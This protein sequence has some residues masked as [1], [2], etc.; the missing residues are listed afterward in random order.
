MRGILVVFLSLFFCMALPLEAKQLN[1]LPRYLTEDLAPADIAKVVTKGITNEKK[2]AEA[3]ARF[4]AS[5]Y[6]RDGFLEKERLNAFKKKKV[7]VPEYENNFFYSK[8]GDSYGFSSLY[9]ELCEAVGLTAVIIE[10]YAGKNIYAYANVRPEGQVVRVASSMLTGKKDISL[11]R[12]K[13]AWNGVKIKDK[14]ILVDTYWMIRGEKTAHKNISSA[15][16]M[17]R[18]LKKAEKQPLKKVNNAIDMTFFD[19][20]PR[21]F[22]KTHFPFNEKWQLLKQPISLYQFLK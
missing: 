15:R 22:I 5:Y 17:E 14:W 7:Y 8:V 18:T 12:Y 6:E 10:G 19:A 16:Q 3:L 21:T 11:E 1:A 2:K 4:V 13:S 9:Q 20:K